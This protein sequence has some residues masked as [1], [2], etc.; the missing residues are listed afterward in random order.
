MALIA[1][2]ALIFQKIHTNHA[3]MSGKIFKFAMVKHNNILFIR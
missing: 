2:P 1:M 3:I